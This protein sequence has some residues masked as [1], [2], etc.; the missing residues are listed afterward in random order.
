MPIG[1]NASGF[2][3]GP[4]VLIGL[5]VVFLLNNLGVLRFSIIFKFWPIALIAFG[6]YL[7]YQ[8]T[9]ERASAPHD[10]TSVPGGVGHE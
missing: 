5:G 9:Q 10:P 2:P 1:G 7:L 4:L 3:A 6:V 8:R